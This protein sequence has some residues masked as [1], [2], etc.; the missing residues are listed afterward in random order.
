MND[1]NEFPMIYECM[2]RQFRAGLGKVVTKVVTQF[3]EL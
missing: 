2:D 3:L 1:F